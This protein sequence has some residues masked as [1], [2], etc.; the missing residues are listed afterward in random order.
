[1]IDWEEGSDK[2]SQTQ[3]EQARPKDDRPSPRDKD[4]AQDRRSRFTP[5]GGQVQSRSRATSLDAEEPSGL[6]PT[7]GQSR[8]E[9]WNG[10]AWN[11][12]TDEEEG[13]GPSLSDS[14][15]EAERGEARS[16]RNP[17]GGSHQLR[18]R[19]TSSISGRARRRQAKTERSRCARSAACASWASSLGR[20]ETKR[21]TPQRNGR[22]YRGG[23]LSECVVP[24]RPGVDKPFCR[25]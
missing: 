16:L 12:N 1:M 19:P 14:A 6:A 9:H 11:R 13:R 23:R 8:T 22:Y 24:A 3:G 5:T 4:G 10:E 20:S 21:R 25:Q 7:G 18:W 15:R 17:A 2:A